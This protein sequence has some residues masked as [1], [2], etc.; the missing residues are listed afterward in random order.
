MADYDVETYEALRSMEVPT[1]IAL[2]LANDESPLIQEIPEAVE[3]LVAVD[4]ED[5]D[6]DVEGEL[7]D[8]ITAHNLLVTAL[9]TAGLIAEAE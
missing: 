2:A 9:R 8:V 1:K 7:L 4:D 6:V 3:L 5:F